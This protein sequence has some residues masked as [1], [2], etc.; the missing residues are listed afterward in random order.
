MQ[1]FNSFTE[2]LAS[3]HVTE[4]G[5]TENAIFDMSANPDGTSS[6]GVP[7]VNNPQSANNPPPNIPQW[8]MS[9][10]EKVN[11]LT[12]KVNTLE[13]KLDS[14]LAAVNQRL[15]KLIAGQK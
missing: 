7:P 8:C 4:N 12:N 9:L 13:Q 1:T 11:K 14:G 6:N 15:D 10:D 5:C 3:E 2:I